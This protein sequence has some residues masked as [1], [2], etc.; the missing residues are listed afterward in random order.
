MDNKISRLVKA[1]AAI[2]SCGGI[3]LLPELIENI[4]ATF[5]IIYG[6]ASG[7]QSKNS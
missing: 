3:I 5:M 1:G 7:A 4:I 6:I 2:L